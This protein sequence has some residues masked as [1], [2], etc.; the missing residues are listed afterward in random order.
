MWLDLPK[1]VLYAHNFKSYF[2]PPFDRYNNRLIVHACTIAK[3]STVYFYWCLIRG[4]IWRPPVLGWSVNGSNFPGQ[5]D[6]RQGITT[7]LAGKTGHWSSYIMWHVELKTAW[8]AAIL[9]IKQFLYGRSHHFVAPHHPPPSIPKGLL[10]VLTALWNKLFK[11]AGISTSCPLKNP[12][13][14]WSWITID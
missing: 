13:T 6:N 3:D 10:V 9:A 1:D 8:I 5:A 12:S 2:S 14:E 7:G 4:P 11:M